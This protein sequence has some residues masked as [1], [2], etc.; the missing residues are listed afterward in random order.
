[1]ECKGIILLVDGDMI[2]RSLRIILEGEGYIVEL[3]ER[4]DKAIEKIRGGLKYD[5]AIVDLSVRGGVDSKRSSDL[6]ESGKIYG[7]EDVMRV[8]KEINPKT[9]VMCFSGHLCLDDPGYELSYADGKIRK[10]IRS[11]DMIDIINSNI[12]NSRARR[13]S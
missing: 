12:K 4:A 7:G 11:E 9:R 1:M 5:I 3:A 6:Q 8:S 2:T 13:I 10:P